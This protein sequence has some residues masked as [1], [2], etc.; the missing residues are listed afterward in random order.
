MKCESK[1][2]EGVSA[3][4]AFRL[5]PVDRPWKKCENEASLEVTVKGQGKM[6]MC[7]SCLPHFKKYATLPWTMRKLHGEKETQTNPANQREFGPDGKSE[8]PVSRTEET[9]LGPWSTGGRSND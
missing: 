3:W 8:R 2:R 6:K 1:I 9:V 5:G 4:T 7:A